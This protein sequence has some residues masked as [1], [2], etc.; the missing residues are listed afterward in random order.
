VV[1]AFLKVSP[2]LRDLSESGDHLAT[3]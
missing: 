3:A 2:V 1:D